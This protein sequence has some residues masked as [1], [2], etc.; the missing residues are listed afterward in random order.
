MRVIVMLFYIRR[1][2]RGIKPRLRNKHPSMTQ[3]YAHL[4]DE[5]LKQAADLAGSLIEEATSGNNDKVIKIDN[6]KN[7]N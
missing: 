5:T 2:R 6:Q 1:K 7:G 3:R 4:R